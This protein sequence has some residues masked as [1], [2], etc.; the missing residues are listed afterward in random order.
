MFISSLFSFSPSLLPFF[1]FHSFILHFPPPFILPSFSPL[2][3][4]ISFLFTPFP[5]SLSTSPSLLS[6]K[7]FR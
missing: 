3:P 2:P 1:S 5:F 7:I 4:F 6:A